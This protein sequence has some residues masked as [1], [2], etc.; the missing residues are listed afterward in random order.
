MSHYVQLFLKILSCL[1]LIQDGRGP[2]QRE[3]R[4]HR[5]LRLRRDLPNSADPGSPGFQAETAA[6]AEKHSGST[7]SRAFQ[8][9]PGAKFA[10]AQE[11]GSSLRVSFSSDASPAVTTGAGH[12]CNSA[13]N[14][15]SSVDVRTSDARTYFGGVHCRD[16]NPI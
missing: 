4:D 3:R 11:F 2:A 9:I 7:G 13:T 6:A 5:W 10:R 15:W 12:R 14:S 8:T 1:Y 16:G